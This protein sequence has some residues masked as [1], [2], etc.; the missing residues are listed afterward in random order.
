MKYL[1]LFASLLFT[2]TAMAQPKGKIVGRVISK[3]EKTVQGATVSLLRVAD[4]VAVQQTATNTEGL[5][6]FEAIADGKY[7]I[8]VTATG[9]R[10]ASSGTIE[11]HPGQPAV[12]A[13]PIPLIPVSKDMT[14]VTVTAKRPLIEQKIDRTLVNVDA[15][16]TNTGVSALEVLEA[17]PGVTVDK[18]GT[19]SLKGKDGVV[20]LIDG[21]PTQL[22][23][24]DLVNLLRS[25]N[26]GQMDQVEIMTN[27]PAK[28]DAS[29]TAGLIN[30]KTKKALNKGYNGSASVAY[31]QGRYPKTSESFSLNYRNDKINWFTNLGHNYNAGFGT[32]LIQRKIFNNS[33]DAVENYFD[34]RGHRISDGNSYNGKM[35]LDYFVNKKTT[36]GVVLNG[37]S[38]SSESD[39][40]S[41]TNISNASKEL[42]RV[43]T[44]A[45]DNS[46][47]WTN[48]GSN[49]NFRTLL[50]TKGRELTAD[51]DFISYHSG[52]NMYMVNSYFD[53]SGNTMVKAD[54][55]L[56]NLP[57][58]I[59]LYGGR[60]DY[61]HPLEK[62]ARFEA[63][64][65][66]S[67]VTTDNKAAY[68]SIQYGSIVRDI[69]R[70]NHF[71]YEENIHAAY[72]NLNQPLSKKLGVQLGLRMEHT[73]AKGRQLTTGEKFTR[74]YTQLFPTAY[75][76][77]KLNEKNTVLLNYGRR[78]RRPGYQSLNPFIRFIDRYTYTRGNPA[79]RPQLSDNVEISHSWRNMI[80]TTL[81]YTYTSDIFDDVIEQKGEEAF[82]MPANIASHRQFGLAISA[83]TPITKWWMSSLAINVFNNRYKGQVSNTP[84]ALEATS[85]VVNG[86]QQFKLNKTLTAEIN[87]RY[88]NGWLEGLIKARPVG[89][90]GTG[91]SQQLMKNKATL[92]LTV[93]DVFY[94][95]KFK[96]ESRYGNVD[97]SFQD[98]R[99]TR[100][101]SIGFTYRFNKGKK[102]APSKKTTG[103]ANE[104]QERIE[105]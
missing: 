80:T 37:T 54:T 86:I 92:R 19:I 13:P 7:I 104:E 22:A 63:G 57:Q 93:R 61:I 91:L 10:K 76:Q 55:L 25:M 78:I 82:K 35:G 98:I 42:E 65:K 72:V 33:V 46:N 66:S 15:L 40:T 21:R 39:N 74:R 70:S 9:H 44:A 2:A 67:R 69:N 88:R 34:Q 49:L 31:T 18:E 26:S 41:V 52:N 28:Y 27:P 99:D 17:A 96:G 105:Q 62:G 77:Y 89:F 95:Q 94:T 60:M 47:D 64:I 73:N 100:T 45:I 36:V 6:R 90:I 4:S 43:V 51:L 11:I 58:Y 1:I 81:N 16:V 83:N 75:F 97:F 87:G 3:P 50:N 68:D 20:V 84:I 24:A 5:Y 85:F 12:Q 32:L 79:L 101:L 53:K 59:K 23:G 38:G 29:G 8:T 103:S 56:G 30:I 71:V 102:I 14:G 48:F